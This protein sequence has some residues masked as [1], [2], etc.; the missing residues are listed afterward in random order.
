MPAQGL[1]VPSWAFD[2]V[3]ADPEPLL[4]NYD[5]LDKLREAGYGVGGRAGPR[6]IRARAAVRPAASPG[7]PGGHGAASAPCS[8][9]ACLTRRLAKAGL[10]RCCWVGQVSEAHG[11]SLAV[12][13]GMH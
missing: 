12:L 3:P 4:V 2:V 7:A 8:S 11:S 1:G 9:S 5:V 13:R 10:R 6:H